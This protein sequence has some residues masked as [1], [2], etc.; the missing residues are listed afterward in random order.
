MEYYN[1]VIAKNPKVEI[2][3]HSW[4]KNTSEMGTFMSKYGIRFPAFRHD[5]MKTGKTSIP[6]VA[7]HIE[8]KLPFVVMLDGQ[9]E[10]V[11]DADTNLDAVKRYFKAQEEK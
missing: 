2:I 11:V 5:I 1:N 6:T 7:P 4:D 3:F 10:R 9:G 8:Q